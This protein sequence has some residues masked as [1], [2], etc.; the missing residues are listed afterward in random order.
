MVR[1]LT[2]FYQVAGENRTVFA[3]SESVIVH[4]A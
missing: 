2:G 1:E 4:A 3:D